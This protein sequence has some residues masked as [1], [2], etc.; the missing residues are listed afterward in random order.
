MGA[1]PAARELSKTVK[2]VGRSRGEHRIP[3]SSGRR[4]GREGEVD[5]R[6]RK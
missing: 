4:R 2:T 5:G 3:L 6:E 1:F